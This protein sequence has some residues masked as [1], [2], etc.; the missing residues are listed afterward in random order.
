MKKTLSWAF[1]R[2]Q[3]V[4]RGWPAVTDSAGLWP[5]ADATNQHR[6]GCNRHRPC[7]VKAEQVPKFYPQLTLGQRQP[8]GNRTVLLPV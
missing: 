5:L 7:D 1:P 3:T 6:T 4:L 8:C 2:K